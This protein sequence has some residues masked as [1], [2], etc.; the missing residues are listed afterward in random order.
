MNG[1]PKLRVLT[2]RLMQGDPSLADGPTFVS[3]IA[4]PRSANGQ[5]FRALGPHCRAVAYAAA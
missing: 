2:L 4:Y 3:A 1:S 5:F